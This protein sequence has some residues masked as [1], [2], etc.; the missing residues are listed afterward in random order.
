[1]LARV[2]CTGVWLEGLGNPSAHT[3]VSLNV[4]LKTFG[5]AI[6]S[7]KTYH[8]S[9]LRSLSLVISRSGGN[10]R[11]R[12]SVIGLV[13]DLPLQTLSP[14]LPC[15]LLLCLARSVRWELAAAAGTFGAY[16]VQ[17]ATGIQL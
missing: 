4:W 14:S 11:V 16:W 6:E 12:A 5:L 13:F 3:K 2:L 1:M 15:G 8:F 10:R 9:F 17:W 7:G